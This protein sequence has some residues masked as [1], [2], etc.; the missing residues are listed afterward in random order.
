VSETKEAAGKVFDK[1]VAGVEEGVTETKAA[2][3]KVIDKA[4]D[5]SVKK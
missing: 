3:K 1:V 2:A 5:N 4:F